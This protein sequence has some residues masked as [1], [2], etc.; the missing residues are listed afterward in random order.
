VAF[1]IEHPTRHIH[2]LGITR[3]P[4]GGW[5]TQLV[6]ESTADPEELGNCFT[7]LI[8]DRDAK[9]TAAST[10]YS[11]RATSTYYSPRPRRRG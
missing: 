1:V 9:F 10:P 2:L 7:H 6:R 4:T 11:Q 5:A 3:Y 8:R